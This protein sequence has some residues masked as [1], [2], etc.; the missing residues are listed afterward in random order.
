MR[1]ALLL[2][3]ILALCGLASTA[4]A[5]TQPQALSVAQGE[6][7]DRIA[8][9]G[10]LVAAPD[11]R[12]AVL[13]QA[14]SDER[15]K[16]GPDRR[17]LITTDTG[18]VDAATGAAVTLSPD[19][20]SSLEDVMLNNRLRGELDGALAALHLT[21]ADQAERLAAAKAL[22]EAGGEDARVA[23]R[24]TAIAKEQDATVLDALKLARAAALAASASPPRS[25]SANRTAPRRACCSTSACP[26][27]RTPA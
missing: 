11:A 23:L 19:A 10:Q 26:T 14:L 6:T 5:L 3:W 16:L 22:M 7:E 18:V 13:L 8:A 9:L 25:C 17:V 12:T 20:Q 4:Q 1:R 2:G 27:N 24:E 21:S 15:V